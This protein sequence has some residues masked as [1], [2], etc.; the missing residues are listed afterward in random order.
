MPT[1]AELNDHHRRNIP[2]TPAV[3]T[4]GVQALGGEMV[5]RIV[6]AVRAFDRFTEDNDPW[7]EHDFGSIEIDGERIFWKIDYYGDS[8]YSTGAEP[9]GPVYRM[10][11]IML[12]SEY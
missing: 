7:G 6:A 1:I 9:D 4:S 5:R 11:T 2:I 10:L 12:A 3:M 8:D